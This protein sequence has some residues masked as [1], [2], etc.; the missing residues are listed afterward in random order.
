MPGATRTYAPSG[1]AVMPPG[2]PMNTPGDSFAPYALPAS[3]TITGIVETV[4]ANPGIPNTPL[5]VTIPSGSPLEAQRFEVYASGTLNIGTSAAPTIKLYSGT[6]STVGQDVLLASSGAITAFTGKTDWWLSANLI[7]DSVN[8]VLT[9]TA[10]FFANNT[11]VAEVAI[12]NKPTGLSNSKNPVAN[13]LLSVTFS[14]AGTQVITV[15]EFAVN[16]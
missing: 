13:F 10:K 4:I 9:G 1:A 12:T 7:F 15:Q 3:Q 14:V 16:F 8:G 11:L 5:I 6:S 2:F